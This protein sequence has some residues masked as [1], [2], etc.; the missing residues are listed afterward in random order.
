MQSDAAS[1]RRA[2]LKLMGCMG[3]GNYTEQNLTQL[4][5]GVGEW[6]LAIKSN[7]VCC[8]EEIGV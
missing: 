2:S 3:P 6:M 7:K 1:G 5:M 8:V 4:G